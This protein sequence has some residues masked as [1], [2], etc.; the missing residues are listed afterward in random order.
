MK[1]PKFENLVLMGKEAVKELKRNQKFMI[2]EKEKSECK[3]DYL[4][5]MQQA[6]KAAIQ[7][8]TICK[9]AQVCFD[10]PYENFLKRIEV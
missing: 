1:K 5:F 4:Y 7:V 8:D 6:K 10:V 9:V 3:D 2:E